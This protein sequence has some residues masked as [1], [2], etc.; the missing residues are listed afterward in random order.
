[1]KK[2]FIISL[3]L[4]SVGIFSQEYR[5]YNPI[6]DSV[7]AKTTV[8]KKNTYGFKS[9]TFD[10]TGRQVKIKDN[11]KL[12]FSD[13]AIEGVRR[14]M[15]FVLVS[16]STS[17]PIILLAELYAET[18][19]G[20]TLYLLNGVETKV[21]GYFPLA[22]EASISRA[23]KTS[24]KSQ[25][26]VNY[27]ILE[28]NGATWRISFKADKIVIHPGTEREEVISGKDAKFVFN[29]KKLKEVKDF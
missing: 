25:S 11:K 22:L 1:M 7:L 15:P 2:Y 3:L 20:F 24:P 8:G 12:I 14:V 4:I 5:K 27:M 26:L 18:L 13:E 16:D 21:I 6:A 29:G 17:D 28:T 10:I 19:S 9:F 23:N